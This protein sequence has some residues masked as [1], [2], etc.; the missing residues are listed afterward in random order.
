MTCMSRSVLWILALAVGVSW[1]L[2]CKK[3]SSSASDIAIA[4]DAEAA[5]PSPRGPVSAAPAT[6]GQPVVIADTGDINATLERLTTELRKY[7]VSSRSV[8]KTFEEFVTKA[9]LE[10]PP[11]PEGKQYKISGQAVVLGKK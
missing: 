3:S 4:A 11:P 10:F 6:A 5:P 9:Q 8:P 1:T 7:V 2:G